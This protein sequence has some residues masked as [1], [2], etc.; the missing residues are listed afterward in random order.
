MKVIGGIVLVILIMVLLSID[1]ATPQRNHL[2]N[3][4]CSM[5]E[6][7]DSSGKSVLALGSDSNGGVL[8][9]G[10]KQNNTTLK[11]ENADNG[12]QITVTDKS[13][14]PVILLLSGTNNGI[15]AV[16]KNGDMAILD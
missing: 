10:D 11:L 14:V 1:V 12:G 15:I 3:V 8:I 5:L 9:I 6:I 2:G 7:V 13:G 4:T 16:K